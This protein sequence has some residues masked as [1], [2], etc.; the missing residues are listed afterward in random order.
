M[1]AQ[2]LC[3]LALAGS[4]QA[5]PTSGLLAHYEFE[6]NTLDSSGNGHHGTPSG[7]LVYDNGLIG[8]AADFDGIDDYVSV[9]IPLSGGPWAVSG[10][11]RF[12]GL[13]YGY[14]DWHEIIS[15]P[16][17]NFALGFA[18]LDNSMQIWAGGVALSSGPNAVAEGQSY[19]FLFQ[20]SGGGLQVWLDGTLLASGGAGVS[21]SELTTIGQWLAGH[22]HPWEREPLNGLLDELRIY[23]RELDESEILELVNQGNGSAA[24]TDRPV[25]FQLDANHP[26]PFNPTTTLSFTLHE[27]LQ[28]RL[29]VTDLQGRRVAVLLDGLTERGSHQLNFDASGLGSGVYFYTLEAAG[30]RETKRML[31]LK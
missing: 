17:Q 26:N 27:T 4:L 22:P 2:I 14:T 15:N 18:P 30:H 25:A 13:T 29:S 21:P 10:W 7:G 6:G 28:A 31:L 5:L 9:S 19:H 23:D 11:V 16:L 1:K 20:Q 24:T 12:D 8:Q 3:A